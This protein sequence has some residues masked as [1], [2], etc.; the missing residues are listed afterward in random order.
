ME[1]FVDLIILVI[2]S[3]EEIY[4]NIINTYWKYLIKH[5]EKNKID[6]KVIFVYN[7]YPE[8][9]NIHKN[10]ILCFND[11]ETLIPGILKKTVNAFFEI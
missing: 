6:I 3:D 4:N 10:N 9:I 11:Q 2:A 1:T 5:I 7:K 8:N